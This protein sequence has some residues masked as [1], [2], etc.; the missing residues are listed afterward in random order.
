MI[1]L[2]SAR[3]VVIK[4]GTGVLTS[5]IGQIDTAR[6]QAHCRQIQYL[7]QQGIEVIVVSSGAI[8]LGM[9]R[10]GWIT[11][12]TQLAKLQACA[13][14]GQA[15]LNNI[16]QDCLN[17]YH[18]T[19]AQVL[20]TREDLRSQQ[21]HN[22]VMGTL[23]QLLAEGVVPIVN[24]NDTV[25]TDEI[26]FGDN[27]TL[28]ALVASIT[29]AD[30]LFILSNIPG[31]IDLEGDGQVIHHIPK[32]TPEIMAM[33]KGTKEITSVGGMVS[34]LTA[35]KI[36]CRAGC[37]T[38]IGSGQDEM[39]MQKIQQKVEIASYFEP[40]YRHL[41]AQQ[42]WLSIQN[43]QQG[44]LTVSDRFAQCLDQNNTLALTQAEI[45]SLEGSFESGSIL[46]LQTQSKQAIAQGLSH[47]GSQD[48]YQALNQRLA[49]TAEPSKVM[50]LAEN[51]VRTS[52]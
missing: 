9:G 10:L 34:K 48:I 33:A 28:A 26:K 14:I 27:D 16:W 32:I 30:L 52:E 31:L 39:L 3:R 43:C 20:L 11:R 40:K 37:G 8:G 21:R 45:V 5:G 44:K 24:E 12:P 22:A 41:T 1:P 46:T 7:R 35:A 47:L 38:V 17:P 49:G 13:A 4:L 36:A 19:A 51:L 18:I 6:I 2:A 50:I 15:I 25:S 42:R 29:E 23:Q